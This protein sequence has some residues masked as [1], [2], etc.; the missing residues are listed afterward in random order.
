MH[1]KNSIISNFLMGGFLA[2]SLAAC[3]GKPTDPYPPTTTMTGTTS[4]TGPTTT[5]PIVTGSTSTS[6]STTTASTTTT[7]P[8]PAPVVMSNFSFMPSALT[9]RAGQTVTWNHQQP[10]AAHTV[11]SDTGVFDSRGGNPTNCSPVVPAA[12]LENGET[13]SQLFASP[14]TF[15]YHCV[16]HGA[17]NGGGMSG[18]ITVNP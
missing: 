5:G 10:G 9:I 14:G 8:P 1:H 16:V 17:P 18:T 13:F 11:T 3:D 2:L 6:T 4:T 15:P 12:C 7:L